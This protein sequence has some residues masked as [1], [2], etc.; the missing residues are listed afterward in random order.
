M[1]GVNP[2]NPEYNQ[3]T[4]R[5]RTGAFICHHLCACREPFSSFQCS[6]DGSS[7]F[8]CR[9][10]HFP[11]SIKV[12]LFRAVHSTPQL[13][14]GPSKSNTHRQTMALIQYCNTNENEC[15]PNGRNTRNGRIE[16]AIYLCCSHDPESKGNNL[17]RIPSIN[18]LNNGRRNGLLGRLSI[19]NGSAKMWKTNCLFELADVKPFFYYVFCGTSK[20]F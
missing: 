14:S 16:W 3:S 20:W 18:L 10:R 4:S 13:S 11:H 17:F 7:F 1:W 19:R 6:I 9:K 15:K 8:T 5:W 2:C 12:K